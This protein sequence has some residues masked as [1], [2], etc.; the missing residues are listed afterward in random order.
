MLLFMVL[1]INRAIFFIYFSIWRWNQEPWIEQ[2]HWEASLTV[3]QADGGNLLLLY[4]LA[5]PKGLMCCEMRSGGGNRLPVGRESA[6][7]WVSEFKIQHVDLNG[8]VCMF[9]WGFSSYKIQD[10][11]RQP[12][13]LHWFWWREKERVE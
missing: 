11:E 6:M 12:T 10:L 5:K 8:W 2:T 1:C 3:F 13:E 4:F 7:L 9:V